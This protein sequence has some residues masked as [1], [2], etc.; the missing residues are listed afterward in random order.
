MVESGLIRHFVAVAQLGSF[1][2]AA[3]ML[4][5][6]QSVVSRNIKRLEDKIGARLLERSTRNVKLSPAGAAFLEDAIQILNRIALATDNARRIANGSVAQLR[7]AICPTLETPEIARGIAEFRNGWPNIEVNLISLLSDLQ[8]DALRSSSV[9]VGIMV[10]GDSSYEALTWHVLG[11][12]PIGVMVPSLWNLPAGIPVRLADLAERPIILPDRATATQWHDGVMDMCKRA[13]FQP[14]IC[15]VVKDPMIARIMIACGMGA[16]FIQDKGKY[17]SQDGMD[18]LPLAGDPIYL[19]GEVV[20]AWSSNATSRQQAE[21][22][23]NLITSWIN[24]D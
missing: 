11:R 2:A 19:P 22:V 18:V 4:G 20:A 24:G 23:E 12:Y 17:G 6:G 15:N 8:P 1:S 5:T 10:T 9:D 3:T 21:L 16:T 14:R 13:G 7:L